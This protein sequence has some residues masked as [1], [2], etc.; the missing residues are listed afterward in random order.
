[1]RTRRVWLYVVGEPPAEVATEHGDFSAFFRRAAAGTGVEL[2]TW[3]GLGLALPDLRACDGVI[4]TG[5]A[6]SLTTPEPWMEAAVE[7]VREAHR[8]GKPLLGV[9][10]GHQVIG[11]AFGGHVIENPRGWEIS[12]W[13]IELNPVGRADPLFEGLPERLTVNFSHRDEVAVDSLSPA[14]GVAVLAGN[15]ASPVQALAAG[16]AVR[17]VQFHPEFDGPVVRAYLRTRA[18]RLAAEGLDP[19]ALAARAADTPHGRAVLHNFMKH[20]V[21]QE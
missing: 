10:F 17:G 9:C 18:E 14:N 11:A 12:T 6:A 2:H 4:M 21:M 8:V 15:P 16:P 13:D 7:L 20:F 19:A 3:N 1:M 5:S